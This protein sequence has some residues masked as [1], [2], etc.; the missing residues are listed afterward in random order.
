MKTSEI[1]SYWKGFSHAAIIVIV[2]SILCFGSLLY[3][4]HK[5]NAYFTR[6]S[7]DDRERRER[8]HQAENQLH[9]MQRLA[10]LSYVKQQRQVQNNPTKQQGS[11]LYRML[12]N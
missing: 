2:I 5:I 3:L 7:E 11:F 10:D 1:S 6:Q 9:N 4:L 8:E 12:G